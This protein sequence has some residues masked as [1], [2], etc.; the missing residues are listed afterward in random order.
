[1]NNMKN[2]EKFEKAKI[3][4]REL[5]GEMTLE[6]KIG[7]LTL[8]N[9]AYEKDFDRVG[10]MIGVHGAE[11]SNEMQEKAMKD[12]PKALPVVIGNDY[13]H[14]CRTT[15]PMPLSQSVTWD[16]E[17]TR[18]CC[19]ATAR[20][21]YR[22]GCNWTYAPMID[23]ARD[24]R[25]GRI[26]EGYGEDTLLA[27]DFAAAAVRGFQ[28]D[29]IGEEGRILCCLK[30]YVAYGAGIGGRDYNTA[31]ISMQTLF[32][33]YLPPF[34]AGV[35]AGAASVMPAYN[36]V[37]GVPMTVHK[38]LL[39]DVLR[40]RLGFE[41]FV[42]SDYEAIND[43]LYHGVCEN[44][45][46]AVEE[47]FKAG[48]DVVMHGDIFNEYLPELVKEGKITEAQID[49]ACEKA[50]TMKI[51][52]G[53]VDNP[54]R[55]KDAYERELFLPEYMELDREAGRQAFTLLENNGVLP[56]TKE[57]AKGKTVAVVGPGANDMLAPLGAWPGY[58][59]NTKTVT[60]YNGIKNAY[61]DVATVVT[62]DGFNW[63]GVPAEGVSEVIET[64]KNA[65]I[66][67]AVIGES[68]SASGECRCRADLD[69]NPTQ[70]EMLA[71]LKALGKPL[72]SLVTTGRPL[73]LKKAKDASDALAVIWQTGCEAGNSVA[74][75]LLGNFNP[76][77]RLTTSFPQT[78]G[79]TPIYYNHFPTG[80]TPED[81]E[82]FV[83]RYHDTP[84]EPLYC[85][86]Y[87]KGYSDFEYSDIRL[88]S[89]SMEKDG[90]I[91]VT[92]KVKNIGSLGGS[93]VVQLYIRD[94]VASRARPV[95]ELKGYRKVYVEAGEEKDVTFTLKAS[96]LAFTDENLRPVV[97]AGKFRLWVA[98]N[99]QDKALGAEF[100]VK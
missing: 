36:D 74:D 53:A 6:E 15:F 85:F 62:C 44:L 8:V 18:R 91:T 37:C 38:F 80:R 94:V 51:M 78:S 98:H 96:S 3:R 11:K 84:I 70:S 10:F 81:R 12:N 59:D 16:P 100:Y 55:D 13:L 72:I 77:G 7:Q 42:V 45:K 90:E 27:S 39:R 4:A 49:A 73:V 56:L 47:S 29:E 71:G 19:E 50:L 61:G 95:C 86:G 48:I 26:T 41:G 64:A 34:A 33:V 20:E 76:S 75:V 60:I 83:S 92:V 21:A 93:D 17:I 25:W 28:G 66:I 63:D 43:L 88:S 68:A 52:C 97:E 89:D 58:C 82:G 35:E 57:K 79:Q 2:T 99:C 5:M 14:G 69:F 67:I 24:P 22:G 1:M 46:D 23:V 30:H 87:G 54:L 31:D 40:D 32:D 65:D 9:G